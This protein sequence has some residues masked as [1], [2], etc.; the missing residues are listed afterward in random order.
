MT[1]F[2]DANGDGFIGPTEVTVTDTLVFLGSTVPTRTVNFSNTFTFPRQRLTLGLMAEY[3]G[4]F[5]THNVNDLFQCGFQR[6]CRAL[7]DPTAPLE[8]QAKAQA[9]TRAFGAYADDGTFVRL[10]EAS[11]RYELSP[12][13]AQYARARNADVI[14]TGRNLFLWKRTNTWDP[15]NVTQ[16]TDASNYSFG[17]LPQPTT[18]LLRL[19]LGF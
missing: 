7:H 9:A 14:L 8:E 15:E 1:G 17:A 12:R 3:K 2:S 13:L 18:F 5:V 4:G 16:S 19:N 10:R 11:V 6:N